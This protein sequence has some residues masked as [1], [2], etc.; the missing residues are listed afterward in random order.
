MQV[1]I[2]QLLPGFPYPAT[3]ITEIKSTS[4]NIGPTFVNIDKTVPSIDFPQCIK[5]KQKAQQKHEWPRN[6][7][8]GLTGTFR[9]I[10]A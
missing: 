2:K 7:I 6:Y 10:A 1:N 9:S 5:H 4:A 8:V 3:L